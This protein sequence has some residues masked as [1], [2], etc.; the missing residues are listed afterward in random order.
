ME[1]QYKMMEIDGK[2]IGRQI[3]ETSYVLAVG[4]IIFWVLKPFWIL[5]RKIVKNQYV[6]KYFLINQPKSMQINKKHAAKLYVGF[7]TPICVGFAVSD[8]RV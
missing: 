8:D 1:N 5:N 4:M 2:S 7:P 3:L 6:G